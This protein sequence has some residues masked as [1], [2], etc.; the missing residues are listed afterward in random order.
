MWE[1]GLIEPYKPEKA[2]SAARRLKLW[3]ARRSRE[4]SKRQD[5][6]QDGEAGESVHAGDLAE[7]SQMI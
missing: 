4:T 7:S 1:R 3:C 2:F 5:R 6:G